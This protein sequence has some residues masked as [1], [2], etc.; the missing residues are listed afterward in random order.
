[1]RIAQAPP[2]QQPCDGVDFS[3]L[4]H[5]EQALPPRTLYWH[6]PHYSDQGGPPA[7]AVLEEDWKLV[8]SYEDD[9]LELYNL[10][11]D[12]GEQY[13]LSSSYQ[14][15]ALEL[16]SKLVAWLDSVNAVMPKRNPQYDAERADNQAGAVSCSVHP[17]AGCGED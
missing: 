10:A 7:G 6:Y 14:D 8:K 15:K 13:D 11:L 9:H 17:V 5:G 4:L 16:N 2:P 1:L 3:G 12:Q